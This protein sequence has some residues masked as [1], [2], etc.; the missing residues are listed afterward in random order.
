MGEEAE[1]LLLI[2][3]VDI[4]KEIMVELIKAREIN[5]IALR[6]EKSEYI[7]E[8]TLDFQL[9]EM[10]LNLVDEKTDRAGITRILI[11]RTPDNNVVEFQDVMDGTG[12][13]KTIRCSDVEIRIEA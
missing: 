4:F 1:K 10:I 11:S 8:Q 7:V 12:N 6:K 3:E 5:L 13:L 2:P 9:N